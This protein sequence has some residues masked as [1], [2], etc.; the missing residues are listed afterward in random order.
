MKVRQCN[1]PRLLLRV[2]PGYL[3]G[4]VKHQVLPIHVVA[5]ETRIHRLR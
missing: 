5:G 4:G 1:T 2:T 3:Q